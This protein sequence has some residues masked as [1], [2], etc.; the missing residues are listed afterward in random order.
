VSKQAEIDA[1]TR[2]V[3]HLEGQLARLA[4]ILA[5]AEPVLRDTNH[6]TA[7][8]DE[9]RRLGQSAEAKL[10]DLREQAAPHGIGAARFEVALNTVYRAGT[11]GYVSMVFF[12]GHT[13]PVQVFAGPT[14]PP[15][16]VASFRGDQYVGA[17]IRRGEYWTVT[18]V[19]PGE[20]PSF[21]GVFTPLY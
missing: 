8:A 20:P 9:A 12:A 18:S 10:R 2:R 1:L 3:G 6:L 14:D 13:G 17:F 5:V 11:P 15:T 21:S 4:Q 19:W 7:L 16:G